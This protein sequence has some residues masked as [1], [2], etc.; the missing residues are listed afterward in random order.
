MQ[1][2]L[3]KLRVEASG[4]RKRFSDT[5]N[6]WNKQTQKNQHLNDTIKQL[7][8]NVRRITEENQQIKQQVKELEDKLNAV[9]I[10]KD[11][12]QGMIFKATVKRTVTTSGQHKPRGGQLGHP[13]KSRPKPIKIDQEKDVYLTQCPHCA[14]PLA[15]TQTTYERIVVDIPVPTTI[16]T[17]YHIQRQWCIRCHKE[18]CGIPAG[19]VSGLRFGMNFLSWLLIQ[20]YRMRTPLEK[21]VELS[22]TLYSLPIT[23]GGIQR[24]IGQ[25][26]HRLSK[27][28]TTI[29]K[30]IRTAPVKHADETGWRIAGQNG[31]CWLF[32]T[33]KAAYY[34]IEET[35]GK[36]VPQRVLKGSSPNSVLVRDDYGGYTALPMEQQSCW[37]HLL[38][39]SH[40]LVILPQVSTEMID[41][42]AELKVLFADI[43]AQCAEPFDL[44]KRQVVYIAYTA[45]LETIEQRTYHSIDSRKV[46]TRIR[47][48]HTNLLTTL[49]HPNVPLT[50]NH[51]ERQ[52]RPMAIIRKIS[53]G[54][55]STA[56]AEIQAV[57]MS[58]VQT[59]ALQSKA[60]MKTLPKL[61]AVPAQNYAVVLEK[62]E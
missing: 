40:D 37:S 36:D 53:G 19:T 60:I 3:G 31:W 22:T 34:T 11:K 12:Y 58:V 14:S 32:A 13:G 54:S 29:L 59:L 33:P 47:H 2:E 17:K 1:E 21:I 61:L 5:W 42:H 43:T 55:R 49:L 51:A 38:R 18:V 56:G 20:K 57:L 28:Y 8:E 10:I 30:T 52:I 6:A 26:K 50:N 45:R 16:T 35:R 15:Q 62:G 4:L 27:N 9:T 41:L 24:I 7:Q 39:V 23:A 25:L 46:Q 44:V 48:Q